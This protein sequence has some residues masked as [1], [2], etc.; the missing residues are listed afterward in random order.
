M[1]LPEEQDAAL[2]RAQHDADSGSRDWA[3]TDPARVAADTLAKTAHLGH[4]AAAMKLTHDSPARKTY[5]WKS[6][7]SSKSYMVVVSRP[8]WLSFYAHDPSRVAWVAVIAYESACSGI[9]E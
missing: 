3:F 1:L 5:E 7:G 8:Y 4:D 2:L 9:T 6:A